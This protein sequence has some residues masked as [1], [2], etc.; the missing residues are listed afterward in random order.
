MERR[1][2][3]ADFTDRVD[4]W[5]T[6]ATVAI[7]AVAGLTLVAADHAFPSVGM[8]PLY[9]P[10]IALAGWRLGLPASCAV[11][12]LASFLN[13]FPHYVPE[14]GLDPTA[15]VSR[16]II[17][18]SAYAFTIAVILALRRAYDRE[19][20]RATH[21]PLT[22]ALN[23]TA[24]DREIE[25]LLG[26]HEAGADAIA[27]AMIDVDDFK[28]INDTHGH[29]AG[30]HVLRVLT[31]SATRALGGT[32]HVYRL[33]GDEFAVVLPL[34]SILEAHHAIERVHRTLSVDLG[35]SLPSATISMGALVFRPEPSLDRA[36]LLHE[37]DR[38][39]YL[40][41]LAGEGCVRIATRQPVGLL[42][43]QL[44]ANGSAFQ[45]A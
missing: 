16:G 31:A 43:V 4:A 2:T 9:I 41:K 37:A 15:A 38:H 26:S 20:V 29:A 24:F 14:I 19:R 18:F 42:G 45:S 5:P 35:R 21:D 44:T 23:R 8:G 39:M 25:T 40:G 1:A 13:I 36:V 10:L 33:G 34:M 3:K 27:L 11:A 28:R 30:D 7:L 32:G 12:V 22:G 17:R 6:G